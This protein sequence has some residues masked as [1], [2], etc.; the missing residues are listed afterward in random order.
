MGVDG[1]A[2]VENA[3]LGWLWGARHDTNKDVRRQ[4]RGK[5]VGP[6]LPTAQP[7]LPSNQA[8]LST[9][10]EDYVLEDEEQWNPVRLDNFAHQ[11]IEYVARCFAELGTRLGNQTKSQWAS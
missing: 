10:R 7:K 4:S 6:V 9:L 3:T 11:L 5:L 8:H 2:G 1:L